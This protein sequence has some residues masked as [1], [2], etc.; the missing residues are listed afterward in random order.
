MA[1]TDFGSIDPIETLK[2]KDV[3]NR[4]IRYMIEMIETADKKGIIDWVKFT[5]YCNE[6][7][8]IDPPNILTVPHPVI[9]RC[10]KEARRKAHYKD[11]LNK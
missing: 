11:I 10:L 8:S 6:F 1:L 4:I 2:F 3:D 5:A 7:G 9:D